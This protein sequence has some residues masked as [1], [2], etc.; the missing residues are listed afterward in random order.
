M[1]GPVNRRVAE[2]CRGRGAPRAIAPSAGELEI[3][4]NLDGGRVHYDA[5][6]GRLY[7]AV[8]AHS[9]AQAIIAATLQGLGRRAEVQRVPLDRHGFFSSAFRM[10]LT[11]E[12]AA[13]VL[14][15]L[16]LGGLQISRVGGSPQVGE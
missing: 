10:L 3:C 15:A 16:R 7:F 4:Y 11:P 1:I 5:G 8:T 12:L 9:P 13:P 2:A 6:S 14:V